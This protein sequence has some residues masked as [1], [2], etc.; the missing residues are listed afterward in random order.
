M[1]KSDWLA[2]DFP[3]FDPPSRFIE[4]VVPQLFSC[5]SGLGIADFGPKDDL[6]GSFKASKEGDSYL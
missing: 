6:E 4:L 1:G 3:R 5:S 2:H